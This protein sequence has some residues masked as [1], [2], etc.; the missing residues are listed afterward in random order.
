MSISAGTSLYAIPGQFINNFPMLVFMS[1]L[2]W[3]SSAFSIGEY[4]RSLRS[5]LTSKNDRLA[6]MYGKGMATT[7]SLLLFINISAIYLMQHIF[8]E[9]LK[10]INS[11]VRNDFIIKVT[12]RT[13]S[14]AIIWSPM[15]II[16]GITVDAT[17]ISFLSYLPWLLLISFILAISDMFLSKRRYAEVEIINR[18]NVDYKNLMKALTK[19]F[20]VLFTFFAVII[21]SNHLSGL[22]FILTV[23][24]VIFPFTLVWSILMRR[25]SS[26]LKFGWENWKSYNNG[27]QNFVMLFLSL[28]LFSEGFIQTAIP[29][30]LQQIFGELSGYYLL[31]FIF[32]T[33]I[34]F[35]LGM[36]GVHPVAT[37]AILIEVLQ[38]LFTTVNPMSIGIVL[39]VSG[40]ATAASAPY[41]INVTLTTQTLKISPYYIT[42]V[43]FPFSILMSAVGIVVAMLLI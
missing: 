33:V 39:I 6:D 35:I 8:L 17:N 4:D 32:M 21:I 12:L 2:P 42:K 19:L 1:M 28:A 41:G 40:L 15:E 34:Y 11:S 18:A 24:L 31:I 38:P 26:F 20:F 22:N 3:M 29:E 43:N 14:L 10:D 9:K 7:L 30:M 13:F 37:I 25:T 27:M 36:I 16:V 5:M 23:S